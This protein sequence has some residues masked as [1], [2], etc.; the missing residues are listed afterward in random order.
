MRHSLLASNVILLL[1]ETLRGNPC[2]VYTSDLLLGLADDHLVNADA[3]VVCPPF[4]FRAGTTD[5]I[6][7]PKVVV[8]VLS[9]STEA[10]DRGDK[11]AGYL[12]LPSVEHYLLVAQRGVRADSTPARPTAASASRCTGQDPSS[13]S[14]RSTWSSPSTCSTRQPSTSPATTWDPPRPVDLRPGAA[15][16]G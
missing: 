8:E 9:K 16:P 15:S 12:A 2:R 7:N 10:Y 4:A 13:H 6:T 11:Q 5:V 3:V 14:S 1:G